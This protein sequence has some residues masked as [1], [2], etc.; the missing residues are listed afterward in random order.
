MNQYFTLFQLKPRFDIDVG[1]L[2]QTYHQLAARFHP[3][4]FVSSSSF[5]QKQ[6]MMMAST[7]ND[8]YRVLKDPINRAAYLLSQQGI[9]ADNPENTSF[10]PDFLMQQMEWREILEE[11]RVH[12]DSEALN[13]LTNQI[14][15]AQV[16]LLN[17]LK[18]A[19]D[20][21]EYPLAVNLVRQGR[22]LNKLQQEITEVHL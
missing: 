18:T 20:Y 8:A 9:D 14:N 1:I 3:D 11:A 6:A 13:R 15:I 17:E 5:E 10:E 2:E 12:G 7:I 19:F 22:L 21:N 4:R 16:S